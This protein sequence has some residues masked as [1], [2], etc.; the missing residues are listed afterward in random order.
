[1]RYDDRVQIIR[2]VKSSG[3][4]GDEIEKELP[5][6]TVVCAIS[7]LTNSD[8]QTYFKD[9][10]K[11]DGFRVHLQG[12]PDQYDG[13]KYVIRD[14]VKHEFAGRRI[15]RNSLVVIVG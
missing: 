11:V 8:K 1:M 9:Q 6:E 2:V 7:G 5:P 4:L 14:G 13:L 10:Y 15:L 12:P 3:Y